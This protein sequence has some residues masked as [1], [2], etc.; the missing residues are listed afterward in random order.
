MVYIPTPPCL[1]LLDDNTAPDVACP[2]HS[3]NIPTTLLA[4]L[5]ITE[6]SDE[7]EDDGLAMV[8]CAAIAGTPLDWESLQI[9]TASDP[10]LTAVSLTLPCKY[11]QQ[12][13]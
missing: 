10:I 12:T 8:M 7:D 3:P 6:P 5:F 2:H 9:A 4:G 13:L 11:N 1:N